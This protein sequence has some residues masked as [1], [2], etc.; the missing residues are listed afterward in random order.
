MNS[1]TKRYECRE[2]GNSCKFSFEHDNLDPDIPDRCPYGCDS[3]WQ[4]VPDEEAGEVATPEFK[5]SDKRYTHEEL[6]T[7][8]NNGF[9][10][11]CDVPLKEHYNRENAIKDDIQTSAPDNSLILHYEFKPCPFC[12]GEPEFSTKALMAFDKS[13]A[14]V[15]CAISCTECGVEVSTAGS[16]AFFK[17]L[18]DRWNKRA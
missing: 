3:D 16:T 15:K 12:G 10:D 18:S 1:K 5:L 17:E 2:C 8:Y 9:R 6:M 4:E 11:A 7:A 14:L 13:N